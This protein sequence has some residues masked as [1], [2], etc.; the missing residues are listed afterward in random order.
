MKHKEL[1][2]NLDLK[3]L[4]FCIFGYIPDLYERP[5]YA[6]RKLHIN[7]VAKRINP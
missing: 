3:K 5:K 6:L 2:E 4:K 7:L 1:K